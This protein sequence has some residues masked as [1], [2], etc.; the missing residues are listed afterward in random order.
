MSFA[1]LWEEEFIRSVLAK[2]FSV[3]LEAFIHDVRTKMEG[4][5]GCETN[6]QTKQCIN[7]EGRA[8]GVQRAI[9]ILDVTYGIT[10]YIS[11]SRPQLSRS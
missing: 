2:S 10:L 4:D 5:S 1:P 11:P 6:L 7:I 3:P 9:N 8:D